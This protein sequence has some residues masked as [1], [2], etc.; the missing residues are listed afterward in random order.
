MSPRDDLGFGY[1][2][3]RT[4]QGWAWVAYGDAGEV[5]EQ[6]AVRDRSVAAACVI[7]AIARKAG[8]GRSLDAA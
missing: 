7:R 5:I 3:L 6:G 1:R 8:A 2:I 4:P